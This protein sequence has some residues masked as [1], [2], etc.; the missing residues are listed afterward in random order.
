MRY[1]P[2]PY[3]YTEGEMARKVVRLAAK[4]LPHRVKRG[5]WLDILITHSPPFGI[6][7]G[8]DRCHVGFHALLKL[9]DWCRPRYLIHGHCHNYDRLRPS[10]TTYGRTLVVNAHP[11]RVLEFPWKGE[12]GR[13]ARSPHSPG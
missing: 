6:H 1:K 13:P 11:Y 10:V 9:M 8:P 7:D 3:Q 12:A 4:L 5:R 2:G